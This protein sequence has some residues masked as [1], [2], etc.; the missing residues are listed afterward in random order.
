MSGCA[1]YQLIAHGIKKETEI[2]KRSYG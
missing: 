2:T 1:P